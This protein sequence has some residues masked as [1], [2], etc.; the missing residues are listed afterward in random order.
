MS[1]LQ[2][3]SRPHQAIVFSMFLS[4]F[5]LDY[6][7]ELRSFPSI[8]LN[9]LLFRIQFNWLEGI[10]SQ[11]FLL[12][13]CWNHL[14]RAHFRCSFTNDLIIQSFDKWIRYLILHISSR[15]L[16]HFIHF[17]IHNVSFIERKA[18]LTVLEHTFPFFV[19]YSILW[20]PNSHNKSRSNRNTCICNPFSPKQTQSLTC[21]S[22]KSS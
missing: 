10:I 16:S 13:C 11:Q 3:H 1:T 2:Q 21:T 22:P 6:H 20:D 19:R 9:H 7:F 14:N 17:L 8:L 12:G 18:I 15:H 4:F 5:F